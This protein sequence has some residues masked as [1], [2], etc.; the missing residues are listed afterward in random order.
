MFFVTFTQCQYSNIKVCRDFRLKVLS[1]FTLRPDVTS[2]A[3]VAL[4]KTSV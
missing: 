2:V 3:C 4:P 1:S